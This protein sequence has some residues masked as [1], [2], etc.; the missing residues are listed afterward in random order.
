MRNGTS[1]YRRVRNA[2]RELIRVPLL[3]TEWAIERNRV[4][5]S[6]QIRLPGPVKSVLIV[7]GDPVTLTGSRG[8]EAMLI[9]IVEKIR[10]QN[11]GCSIGIV[12]HRPSIPRSLEE[13]ELNIEA[14]WSNPS[15]SLKPLL[16]T[17]SRY[18]SVAIVGGDV[19][20]GYYSPLT[21]LRLWVLG[22][23]AARM[24]KRSVAV[25][26]SF[27]ESPS[28]W[29]RRSLSS[30]SPS[31]KLLVRDPVSLE[32]FNAFSSVKA[33]LVADCAF[34]LAPQEDHP[35]VKEVYAWSNG[36][37]LAGRLVCGFNLHPL[38]LK[39]SDDARLQSVVDSAA[40]AL[41]EI[42]RRRN[43]SFLL[44]A[45]DF[46]G[47]ALGDGAVLQPIYEKLRVELRERIGYWS[48]EFA[49][50]ELKAIAGL[51][52]L[53][54]TGRM[55]LSIA[56]LGMGVPV[57]GVTYQGKFEGLFKHFKLP[58]SLLMAP[59]DLVDS[60]R[61]RELIESLIDSQ[62][63]MKT[64]VAKLWPCVERLAMLNVEPVLASP[65][66]S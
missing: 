22:D 33:R 61:L 42:A 30:I 54:I 8:D 31:M 65:S 1:R 21:A 59:E 24:G 43:V 58:P 19:M 18:D 17:V 5:E 63:Q 20:D 25:G 39:S 4:R 34:L 9:G 15:W 7:S 40:S 60:F 6:C 64:H 53:V 52:D 51:T 66:G 14:V 41:S 50:P 47:G 26:F 62:P 35:A 36:Q 56:A 45:H 13:L 44:I 55:H 11:R 49:A 2:V 29:L 46:R 57:A 10:Y 23:L 3:Y 12:S 48:H 38:L 37:R 16:D 27:N 32:R 28:R